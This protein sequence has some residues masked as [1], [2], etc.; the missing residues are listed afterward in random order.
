MTKVRSKLKVRL[1]FGW[2]LQR[3]LVTS[4]EVTIRWMRYSY[5]RCRLGRKIA[6][7][8]LIRL[9]YLSS[10]KE[11]K[12]KSK[13]RRKSMAIKP[14]TT[15]TISKP[16]AHLEKETHTVEYS[17]KKGAS[18]RLARPNSAQNASE[19]RICNDLNSSVFHVKNMT[20]NRY[21]VDQKT[22]DSKSVR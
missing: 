10:T 18:K 13:A 4:K 21:M 8:L 19:R 1:L 17:G 2:M 15:K 6:F 9:L 22:Y 5:L 20:T 12:W 16:G 7:E 14:E 11:V 3:K